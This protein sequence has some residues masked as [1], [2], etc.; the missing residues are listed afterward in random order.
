MAKNKQD[1]NVEQT[2]TENTGAEMTAEQ[3][4]AANAVA[5]AEAERARK[6]AEK[7]AERARKAEEQQAARK[8]KAEQQQAA[9]EAKE[10]ERKLKAEKSVGDKEAAKAAREEARRVKVA[11]NEQKKAAAKAAKE[12]NRMPE[13]N[14]VRRPKP[15]TICG[16]VWAEADRISNE[17]G[18]VCAV[19]QLLALCYEKTWVEGNVRAEY[20]RWRK[21]YGITGRIAVSKPVAETTTNT[22]S[23][24]GSEPTDEAAT[25]EQATA[26]QQPA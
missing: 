17:Q 19:A 14:G 16:Q 9:R 8:L 2:T 7:E 20:A 12:A 5:A 10:A 1:Q 4:Q 11:E 23:G 22:E 25:A 24:A 3:Q 18:S 26:E 13:Q 21:Y 15:D 6:K